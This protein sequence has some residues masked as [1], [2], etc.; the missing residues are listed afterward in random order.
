VIFG[1]LILFG[2]ITHSIS[3][4]LTSQFNKLHGHQNGVSQRD[5]VRYVL[6]TSTYSTHSTWF[7]SCIPPQD[8]CSLASR[9]TS[10]CICHMRHFHIP[11]HQDTPGLFLT[12]FIW[13]AASAAVNQINAR[14]KSR[15]TQDVF[16]Q[17]N[18]LEAAC[19]IEWCV[20]IRSCALGSYVW[21][22]I[23]AEILPGVQAAVRPTR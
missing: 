3:A 8:Q 12:W 21:S 6:F 23:L 14:R 10:Y 15:R 1:L 4:W 2:I 7:Y 22:S 9:L 16:S 20:F 18:A 19:W 5:R 13:I 17:L 11:A